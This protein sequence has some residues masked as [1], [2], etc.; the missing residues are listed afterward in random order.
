M[1][2][3]S[4]LL[5]VT[6]ELNGE[7]LHAGTMH[8]AADNW[9]EYS[10]CSPPILLIF[11]TGGMRRKVRANHGGGGRFA[12][13]GGVT[14]ERVRDALARRRTDE[15]A[16]NEVYKPIIEGLQSPFDQAF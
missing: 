9:G 6:D 15:R 14:N 8:P 16:M 7:E 4:L 1:L 3:C 11:A 10:T 12:T 13:A 5:S 2:E